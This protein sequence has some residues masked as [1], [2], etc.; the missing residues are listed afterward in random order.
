MKTKIVTLFSL[1]DYSCLHEC[2]FLVHLFEYLIWKSL[3]IFWAFINLLSSVLYQL[4]LDLLSSS[5]CSTQL[6]LSFRIEL[7]WKEST[8]LN[9][10]ESNSQFNSINLMSWLELDCRFTFYQIFY[11]ILYQSDQT[12][13][14]TFYH[15]SHHVLI[16]FLIIFSIKLIAK[17]IAKKFEKK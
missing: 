12:F 3:I 9:R 2:Y 17:L 1:F 16:M 6:K 4:R 13:Y 14:Q 7:S 5:S 11:Q 8:Q 15:I 10:V